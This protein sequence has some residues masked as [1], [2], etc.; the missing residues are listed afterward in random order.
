MIGITLKCAA[1]ERIGNIH[2]LLHAFNWKT[3]MRNSISQVAEKLR[4]YGTGKNDFNTGIFL[5]KLLVLAQIL[6]FL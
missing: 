1:V 6:S 5:L 4:N 3:F 2:C